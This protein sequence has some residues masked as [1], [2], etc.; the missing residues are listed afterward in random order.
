[1][2]SPPLSLARTASPP[3][4]PAT[5]ESGIQYGRPGFGLSTIFQRNS[6]TARVARMNASAGTSAMALRECSRYSGLIVSKMAARTP[7]RVP[8]NM[9]PRAKMATHP[10]MPSKDRRDSRGDQGF[11]APDDEAGVKVPGDGRGPTRDRP[12]ACMQGRADQVLGQGREVVGGVFEPEW[13]VPLLL[14]EEVEEVGL[15]DEGRLVHETRLVAQFPGERAAGND[16]DDRAQEEG[17]GPP[18]M[19]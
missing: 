17:A 9:V 3:A 10:S 4:N 6:S 7:M 16:C 19:R 1:M 11:G 18:R 15:R 5:I 12:R 2:A 14:D 13:V 8:P